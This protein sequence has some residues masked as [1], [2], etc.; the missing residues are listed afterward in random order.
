[1]ELAWQDLR[2][3]CNKAQDEITRLRFSSFLNSSKVTILSDK[4]DLCQEEITELICQHCHSAY[5]SICLALPP[6]NSYANFS[7]ETHWDCPSCKKLNE[8]LFSKIHIH[9]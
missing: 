3:S 2:K 5:H 9:I 1:M 7:Y 6:P 8:V 4:C